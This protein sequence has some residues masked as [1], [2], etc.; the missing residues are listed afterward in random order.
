MTNFIG[1]DADDFI[2]GDIVSA[3]TRPVTRSDFY[4]GL[5]GDDVIVTSFPTENTIFA[6]AGNDLVFGPRDLVW[7]ST[8]DAAANPTA[9]VH[10][11]SAIVDLGQGDDVYVCY[12]GTGDLDGGAGIDIL[13]IA[14]TDSILSSGHLQE[15]TMTRWEFHRIRN[16]RSSLTRHSERSRWTAKSM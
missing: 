3:A 2:E 11:S 6:G 14:I 8:T 10:S 12:S 4:Q 7:V 9:S 15:T 16:L 1:T 13:N 5:G